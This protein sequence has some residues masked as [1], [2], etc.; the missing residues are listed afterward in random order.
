MTLPHPTSDTD[1]VTDR[2]AGPNQW[3]KDHV[4]G[5]I[6]AQLLSGVAEPAAPPADA[7]PTRRGSRT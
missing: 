1:E 3:F 7:R 5:L 6:D 4:D 2:P